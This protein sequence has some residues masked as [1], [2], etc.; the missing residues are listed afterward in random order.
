[1]EPEALIYRGEVVAMLFGVTDLN[2]KLD[3]IIY[4]LEQG[5]GV[6]EGPEEDNG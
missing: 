6:E 3:R 5:F 4:L 2:V 1:V